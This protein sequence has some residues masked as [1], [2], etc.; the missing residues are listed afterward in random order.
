VAVE[1]GGCFLVDSGLSGG[2]TEVERGF[3][4]RFSQGHNRHKGTVDRVVGIRRYYYGPGFALFVADDRVEMAPEDRVS[5][6]YHSSL[7]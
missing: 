5:F 4:G 7:F 1:E 3:R 6:D 2:E